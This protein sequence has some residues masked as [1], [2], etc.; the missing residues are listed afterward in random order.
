MPSNLA[1]FAAGL[2]VATLVLTHDA[3]SG[4]ELLV[5][6]GLLR[7]RNGLHRA[8]DGFGGTKPE[9]DRHVVDGRNVLPSSARSGT[10][11]TSMP[12]PDH[13]DHGGY[14]NTQ[15][16]A[17][18]AAA[19]EVNTDETTKRTR[20]TDHTDEASFPI[21]V[22]ISSDEG[23]F[24]TRQ[25]F[26]AAMAST[27]LALRLWA[28]AI[29]PA[30]DAVEWYT[31]AGGNELLAYAW[32]VLGIVRE[33]S[34]ETL[35]ACALAIA[36]LTGTRVAA[37]AAQRHLRRA[38][39]RGR[40]REAFARQRR[41][42]V[43]VRDKTIAP[44]VSLAKRVS[45]AF[46]SAKR[47][48]VSFIAGVKQ[49][50]R[51][52]AALAPHAILFG[53]GGVVTALLPAWAR[54]L[55]RKREVVASV[56]LIVPTFFTV[57]ALEKCS[58][59]GMDG[60]SV[61]TR[62]GTVS[63]TKTKSGSQLGALRV[64]RVS[65]STASEKKSA[66]TGTTATETSPA[67]AALHSAEAWL[68]FWSSAAPL[69]FLLDLPLV[70][71][72]VHLFVPI[73]PELTLLWT[74]WL[75]FPMTNGAKLLTSAAA[76]RLARWMAS[77]R[78]EQYAFGKQT[79]PHATNTSHKSGLTS[80][81]LTLPLRRLRRV[82]DK[83]AH[84]TFRN[85]ALALRF[86]GFR[87]ISAALS[88]ALDN[89]S[90]PMIGCAVFFFTPAFLT[91]HGVAT[92][93]LALPAAA[94]LDALASR[95]PNGAV[96]TAAA[97]SRKICAHLRYWLAYS[98]VWSLVRELSRGALSWFP[99]WRHVELLVVFW[100]A[101]FGGADEVTRRMFLAK[102]GIVSEHLK[103]A[104]RARLAKDAAS[105]GRGVG[106]GGSRDGSRDSLASVPSVSGTASDDE[107][108][109]PRGVGGH[110]HETTDVRTRN[111]RLT[112][113]VGITEESLRRRVK[114][115]TKHTG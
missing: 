52:A 13:E 47:K 61:S 11:E 112:P 63:D 56:T 102:E 22:T 100:L 64:G 2:F 94:S 50:S 114:E 37:L 75:T 24:T 110:T 9:P 19:G 14:G 17:A 82:L 7:G 28:C 20:H 40:A 57:A 80:R 43:R 35:A 89:A 69:M 91:A 99:L 81:L 41:R 106:D 105:S 32:R 46:V 108:G 33:A 73:W 58:A 6:R 27:R 86:L 97:R 31:R 98:M 92:A 45:S 25:A 60:M 85:V 68:R 109:S 38:R 10:E 55:V 103:A 15:K 59:T 18:D 70:A 101:V 88:L 113:D 1:A 26:A 8:A 4:D 104:A 23:A 78:G 16:H 5:S 83:G 87:K 71:T 51:L 36:A 95:D 67:Q 84:S 76:P 115:G 90:L 48:Y 30:T 12:Y 54:A 44:F 29:R 93:A 79:G 65:D 74:A 96:R 62:V 42:L 107:G 111:G 39:Y 77:T 53:V 66:G 72:G 21:S 49:K 34:P 3:S